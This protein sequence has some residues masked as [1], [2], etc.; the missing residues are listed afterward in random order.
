M[1]YLV[2]TPFVLQ[3]LY[4]HCLWEVKTTEK[5]LFLTF[6]D[7]PTPEV[8][9]FV[10]AELKKYQAA[11]TFFCIGKN[12]SRHFKIYK[13][14]IAAGHKPGNH[15]FNHLNGWKTGDKDYLADVGAAAEIIDSGLFRP[16][17]GRISNF[18]V[19]A[20]EGDRFKLKTVMWTVL[21]GDFDE[22]ITA[23]RC[24]QNVIKNAKRG[25]I[26]VFHDSV[27]AFSKLQVVLPRVLEFFSTRGFQFKSL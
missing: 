5:A 23:E 15:T 6:D 4:P 3:K 12:V 17:Y 20:L 26:V 27:K 1:F 9:A 24:Y 2:K 8:T 18:K 10:L 13:Q 22:R 19:R 11:A 16:P 14:L 7:G 25:S 21:S